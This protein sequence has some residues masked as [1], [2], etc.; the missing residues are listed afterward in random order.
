M[1][2]R[3]L[4]AAA[5]AAV[6]MAT[7]PVTSVWAA[8][9]SEAEQAIAEA[10]AVQQKAAAAGIAT[11]DTAALIKE[12]EGLLP[13]RG[14][15]KAIELANKA[16]KQDEFALSQAGAG[17]GEGA[18]AP[19]DSAKKAEAEKAIADAEAARKKAASVA[20]EWRD[21]KKMINEA[22]ELVKTGELEE[23]IKKANKAKRQGELGYAQALSQK[24][25]DF[26]SY[27]LQKA[28]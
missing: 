27:V 19:V 17:K 14:Y 24:G 2:I 8:Y 23:A 26:P 28:K 7:V 4:S 21:T 6:L 13:M 16:K 10:K 15:T 5:L 20:G 18:A 11:Q 1:K 22:E 9:R 12:A 3:S 25:A